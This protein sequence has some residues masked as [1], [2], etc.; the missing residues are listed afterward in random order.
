MRDPDHGRS[1]STRE[2]AVAAV[3][4]GSDAVYDKCRVARQ[5]VG[6][7]LQGF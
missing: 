3:G 4:P 2:V 6:M 5:N 7:Q 1:E